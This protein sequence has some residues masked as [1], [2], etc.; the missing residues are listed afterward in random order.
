MADSASFEMGVTGRFLLLCRRLAAYWRAVVLLLVLVLAVSLIVNHDLFDVLL[1]AVLLIFIASQFFWI[2]R[3]L[4]S[5]ERLIPGRPRRVW[6]ATIA[7]LIYL[8]VF[9]YSYPEWALGHVIRAS[10]YRLQSIIIHAAFWWWFVGSMLAFL[11]IIAFATVD[12]AIRAAAL[13]YRKAREAMRR[14]SAV[15]DSAAVAD[16]SSPDRRRFLKQTAVLVSATPFVAAGYGLLYERL[17]V[18]VVRQRIRLVRLPRAFEGF[19]IAQ[20]SDIHIGPFSTAEYIQRCVTITNGLKP[21]LIALTGDYVSWDPADQGEV[22]RVL[23]GL[24]APHGV[25]GCLGNHEADTGIEESITRLFAAQGI[26][27]LR[28]ERAPIT[29]RG[30]TINLIGIDNGS[31][32][33]PMRTQEIEGYRRLQ[34]LK[35]LV[36]PDAVNVLLIHYPQFFGDP[37]PYIDLTLAGDLHGGGQ[38]SLDFVHRGFNLARLFGVPYVRGLFEKNGAQL[39]MNRGIGTTGFPIRLGARPEIT[40]LELTRT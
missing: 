4:D 40:L 18:E 24:R 1:L 13:V 11:L 8:F 33:V 3:I 7:A 28:Q 38:L 20:L 12:R 14:P 6:L 35:G 19:Y 10:D 21:D 5:G 22:V 25:F 30:E 27:I 34:Q 39:Y 15:A 29:V 9:G 2:G 32:V 37:G 17:D 31:D 16:P 36:M 26:R 23:A